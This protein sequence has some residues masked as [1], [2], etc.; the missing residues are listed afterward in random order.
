MCQSGPYICRP[1]DTKCDGRED[2]E[3]GSDEAN[4]PKEKVASCGVFEFK[5]SN[6]KCIDSSR[7]CDAVPDC[8]DGEDETDPSC[9]SR[10]VQECSGGSCSVQCSEGERKCEQTEVCITE[11]QMCDGVTDCADESDEMFCPAV[12]E[13]ALPVLGEVSSRPSDQDSVV[14]YCGQQ[15]FTCGDGEFLL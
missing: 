9:T 12:Q 10:S 1:N 15:Q 3:D 6:S 13:L 8:P 4:C 11:Q 2:C 14:K 5:C 7:V